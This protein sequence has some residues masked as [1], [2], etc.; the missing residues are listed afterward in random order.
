MKTE[1]INNT[2]NKRIYQLDYYKKLYLVHKKVN[3]TLLIIISSL[4]ICLI[5]F[6]VCYYL[7]F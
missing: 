2:A 3:K 1:L 4:F 7:K 5:A 6:L